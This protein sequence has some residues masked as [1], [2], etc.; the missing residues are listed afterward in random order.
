MS[1]PAAA[2]RALLCDLFLEVGPDA[3]TLCGEW[4]TRDLA[5]HLVIRERRPDAGPGILTRAFA[6]YSEHVRQTEAERPFT[7]IV[8][9]V[10][11]GPPRYTP[12][13][14]D[15]IDRLVNTIE[16]FVH[17]EDVRRARQPWSPRPLPSELTEALTE[18]ISGAAARMLVRACPTGLAIEPDGAPPV[19]A[20]A[21]VRRR[22]P[23]PDRSARS[24]C[25]STGARPWPRWSWTATRTPSP[26]SRGA[27]RHLTGPVA[28]RSHV[29]RSTCHGTVAGSGRRAGGGER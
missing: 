24:C 26:R 1:S 14:V 12:M 18:L 11:A 21:R 9:R 23:S 8:E 29:T 28:R 27:V 19:P 15:A 7:E 10:R 3:P 16:F 6:S 25:S 2:E 13:R 4:T 17:H 22:S 5:A 20:C